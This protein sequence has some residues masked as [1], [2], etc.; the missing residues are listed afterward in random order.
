M[1]SE[2][3]IIFLKGREG[4]TLYADVLF[5]INFSMDFLALFVCSIILHK[6]S[7]KLKLVVSSL[8]GALYAVIEVIAPMNQ[9]LS[10]SLSIIV[11]LLMCL[12]AFF[13]K[14]I[15]RFILTFVTFW[16]VSMG[17]A[18]AMSLLY[19]LLN[20]LLANV[21]QNYSQQ[22]AY[23]G[24]RFFIISAITAI[25]AI[26][27]SRTFT[28]KKDI[29]SVEVSIELDKEIY[30]FSA[31]CDSGNMLTEPISA[32]PVILVSSSSKIGNA[33][34]KCDDMRKR[35]I[36]Y[37]D[38]TVEGMLLGIIPKRIIVNNVLVDAIVAPV[39]KKSF[40]EYEGLVP[41]AL[42]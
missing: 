25:V 38:T 2:S 12:I 36:P 31:L 15:K 17:L 30:K 28:S 24:A 37:S 32:K 27:F 9:Y 42:L 23:N 3:H 1:R 34:K 14:N 33:I 13:E 11:S 20:K 19:S 7:T 39:E 16:I 35:Y 18:G 4:M 26:V 6:K 21:I 40:A 8:A 5:A 22:T 29:K 41:T 10:I